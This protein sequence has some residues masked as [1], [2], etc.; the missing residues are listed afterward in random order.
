QP[1]PQAFAGMR[2]RLIGP[3]RG[4]R[5]LA[6]L[7]VPGNTNEYLFGAVGGGV[8]KTTSAGQT[9]HPIFDAQAIASIGAIEVAAS[10]PNII[11]VGSGEADM[12]SDISYGDGVYKSADGG[13]TWQNIGLRDSR[14]IGRILVDPHDPNT[15]LVAALGH[16]F[17]PNAERGVYR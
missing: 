4:G 8:W 9:W 1:D 16:G 11:Y 12:R 5:A 13:A 10:N 15:V 3:F 14:Q 17:G 6:A 7:G 2:W